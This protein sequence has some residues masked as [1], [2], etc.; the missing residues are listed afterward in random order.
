MGYFGV[1]F[2]NLKTDIY[3]NSGDMILEVSEGKKDLY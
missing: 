1:S 2:E 3:V